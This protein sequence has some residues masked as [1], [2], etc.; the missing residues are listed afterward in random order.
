MNPTINL[1]A[2]HRSVRRF[3]PTPVPD[4]DVG[5]AVNAARMASTSSWIQA[6][7]LLQV[8]TP[9]TRAA[10][11]TLSGDQPQ[12]REAGAFFVLSGDT[13]RHRL[14]AADEERTYCGN[15]E[16]FLT[17]V[18]DASLFAQNLALAFESMGYGICMIGGLRNQ[19]PEVGELLKLPLGVWPLFGLCVGESAEEPATRPRLPA[20]LLWTKNAYPADKTVRA[21]LACYDA[22]AAQHYEDRGL[23]GRNWSGGIARK[24]E[25]LTR[26]HLLD[27]YGSKG[28][29][30][31]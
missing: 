21:G 25:R 4:E 7:H 26:Q 29:T 11:A 15:L 1:M 14:I 17:V 6:Y 30:L 23:S 24:F 22:E 19:L 20:E 3:H 27:F 31:T 16:T 8:T 12:V 5:A 9:T 10:L 13:R 18:A 2:S 28:A